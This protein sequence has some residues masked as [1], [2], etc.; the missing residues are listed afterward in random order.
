MSSGI[1]NFRFT[2]SVSVH[3]RTKK[4]T[5]SY[6]ITKNFGRNQHANGNNTDKFRRF[7]RILLTYKIVRLGV[8]GN[9]AL[10]AHP[11]RVSMAENVIS[12]TETTASATKQWICIRF[13][14]IS[15]AAGV[16]GRKVYKQSAIVP[17]CPFAAFSSIT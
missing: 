4:R 3:Y 10:A 15:T 9:P 13:H 12:A 17:L 7:R 14:V 16:T 2:S 6:I 1:D 8:N 11:E 5:Y